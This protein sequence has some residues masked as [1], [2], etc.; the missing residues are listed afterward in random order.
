MI[1][2]FEGLESEHS[3]AWRCQDSLSLRQ[4]LGLSLDDPIS[5]HSSLSRIRQRL[6]V[7]VY[8]QFQKLIVWMLKEA[9]LLKGR[10]LLGFDGHL[11]VSTG[12]VGVFV[13]PLSLLR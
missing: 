4:F 1:G 9:G 12:T 13:D 6:D 3:I 2:Y 7:S 11:H 8:R 10:H 5:D